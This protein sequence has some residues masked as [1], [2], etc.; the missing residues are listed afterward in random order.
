MR[1]AL[2]CVLLCAQI[3][4]SQA[5]TQ[6]NCGKPPDVFADIAKQFGE[7]PAQVFVRDNGGQ[8]LFFTVNPE[9][10]TWTL[11]AQQ[12]ADTICPVMGGDSWRDLTVPVK[13]EAGA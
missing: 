6:L 7:R 3:G 10:G 13:P 4:A 8:V 11:F 12:S 1:T 9:T 5:Q 2:A